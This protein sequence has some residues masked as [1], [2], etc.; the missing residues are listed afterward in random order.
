M[1]ASGLPGRQP[2]YRLPRAHTSGP[3]EAPRHLDSATSGRSVAG[4]RGRPFP[5]VPGRVGRACPL[6]SSDGVLRSGVALGAAR[7]DGDAGVFEG[8]DGPI[9]SRASR[10]GACTTSVSFPPTGRGSGLWGGAVAGPG[11][12]GRWTVTQPE[13]AKT[14]TVTRSVAVVVVRCTRVT[15]LVPAARG[16]PDR[17]SMPRT[18]DLPPRTEASARA[19]GDVSRRWRRR[20]ARGADR[21]GRCDARTPRSYGCRSSAG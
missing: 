3:P 2:P 10:A 15:L 18:G 8:R 20:R 7:C 16:R 6:R 14:A 17:H 1:V 9:I 19:G 21:R 12:R 11:A 4:C 5:T 13:R